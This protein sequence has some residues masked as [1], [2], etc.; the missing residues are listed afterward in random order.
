MALT[1]S[2]CSKD[3]TAFQEWVIRAF[4]LSP[5]RVIGSGIGPHSSHA[6]KLAPGVLLEKHSLSAVVAKVIGYKPGTVRSHF[7]HHLGRTCKRMKIA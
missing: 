7:Y 5:D 3:A 2:L 6:M 1:V 4:H